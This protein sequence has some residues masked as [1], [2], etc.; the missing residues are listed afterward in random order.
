MSP[1][2]DPSGKFRNPWPGASPHGLRDFL[3]WVSERRRT[4][5]TLSSAP[6]FPSAIPAFSAPR[7]AP[8]D[9]IVTWVG[10]SSFLLQIGSTNIL[11]DPIWSERAS[12]V[13]F[14]GPKRM[15]TPGV[16]F[17]SL[18]PIDLIL[19]SHDHYDHLDRATVRRLAA[20]HP[21]AEWIAPLEVGEWLRK[22][23]VTVTAELDWWQSVRTHQLD[24]T[25]TPAQHFSGRRP[26]N[27]DST[28][29]CGW[30]IRAGGRAVFFAGDTGRHPEFTAITQ[31]L[32][33]FD[34]ALCPSAPTIRAGSWDPCTWRPKKRCQ[35]TR[36]SRSP[37]SVAAAASL[38]CIGERSSSLTSQWTSHP[39]S[40]AL[41]GIEAAL[42]PRCCGFRLAER[43]GASECAGDGNDEG[44]RGDGASQYRR[45]WIPAFAGMTTLNNAGFPM[46]SRVRG[47][48]G[49]LLY[50]SSAGIHGRR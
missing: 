25:C 18:P 12:P 34:A 24:V 1:H 44:W 42:I 5:R 46:D 30:V 3:K 13:S 35:R 31:R 29:W 41:R 39:C 40:R 15:A 38:R 28:L 48:D 37:T 7:A 27:R 26:N 4:R 32:G 11:F 50:S 36:T 33:P 16:D 10:H 49:G 14:A 23:N 21:R 2:R 6:A 8:D 20:A 45:P 22:R 17:D 9:V 43:L 47:N 19:L